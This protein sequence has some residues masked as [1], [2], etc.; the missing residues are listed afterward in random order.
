[1]HVAVCQDKVCQEGGLGEGLGVVK[2]RVEGVRG[3][4]CTSLR[5]VSRRVKACQLG[6]LVVRLGQGLGLGYHVKGAR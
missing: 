6:G 1:M 4:Q 2:G 3:L 5:D